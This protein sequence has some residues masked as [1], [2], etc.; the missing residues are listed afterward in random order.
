MPVVW[1]S[2]CVC[3]T[4]DCW[5]TG[6][7]G[8]G[9]PSAPAWWELVQAGDWSIVWDVSPFWSALCCHSWSLGS[10]SVKAL[11]WRP[12]RTLLQ[13]LC[14]PRKGSTLITF[15]NECFVCVIFMAHF[16]SYAGYNISQAYS[17]CSAAAILF[18]SLCTFPCGWVVCLVDVDWQFNY[19]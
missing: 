4:L 3:C 8:P 7:L 5:C 13:R 9:V 1:Q 2:A 11:N 10:Q 12:Q 18:W 15:P 17:H 16:L 14:C 19:C 6:V